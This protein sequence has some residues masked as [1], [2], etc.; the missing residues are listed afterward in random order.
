MSTTTLQI[1]SLPSSE[2]GVTVATSATTWRFGAWKQLGQFTLEDIYVYGLQ[3]QETLELSGDST[4]EVLF[5]IGVGMVGREVTKIQIPYSSRSDTS[6]TAYYLP[7]IGCVFLPEPVLI[8]QYSTIS[9]R[10]TAGSGIKIFNGIKLRYMGTRALVPPS[11][12]NDNVENFKGVSAGSGISVSER[13][14]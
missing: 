13:A 6:F 9:V 3:W 7:P 8:P 11:V 14:W 10:A 1:R 4:H 2:T 12:S 5:E